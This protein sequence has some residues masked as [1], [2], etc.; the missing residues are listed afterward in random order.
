MVTCPGGTGFKVRVRLDERWGSDR[1]GNGDG[2]PF[3]RIQIPVQAALTGETK[4]DV[5]PGSNTPG[6]GFQMKPDTFK[7]SMMVG[8]DLTV[9]GTD[10]RLLGD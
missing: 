5:L 6:T 3:S 2:E 1:N 7:K 10:S 8:G 4:W 9:D